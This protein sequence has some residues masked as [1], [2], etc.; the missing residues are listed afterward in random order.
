M[1]KNIIY[2]GNYTQKYIN[3][4]FK[5]SGVYKNTFKNE[6]DVFVVDEAHRFNAKSAMFKNIGE[7]QIKEII[8]T[9]F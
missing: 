5:G 3:N 6:I 2:K 8:N 9:M 7:N 4:L 1:Y